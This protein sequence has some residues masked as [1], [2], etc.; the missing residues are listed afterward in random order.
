M[1]EGIVLKKLMKDSARIA[2]DH[3]FKTSWD[4][5]P[6]K[7]MLIVSELSE[8]LEE[9]RAGRRDVWYRDTD[10]KPEGIGMELADVQIRLAELCE[11]LEIDLEACVIE[12]QEFNKP[13]EFMHGKLL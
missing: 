11:T 9:F 7:L 12:K 13:R 5:F 3:G 2:R 4:N 1:S 6:E 10:G 8:S